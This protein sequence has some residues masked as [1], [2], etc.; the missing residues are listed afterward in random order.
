MSLAYMG[1]PRPTTKPPS[2]PKHAN[3]GCVD[4]VRHPYTTDGWLCVDAATTAAD[5]VAFADHLAAQVASKDAE[6]AA[7]PAPDGLHYEPRQYVDGAEITD[8]NAIAD[9]ARKG[10]LQTRYVATGPAT[11]SRPT[12][13]PLCPSTFSYAH[14]FGADG[15]CDH[16]HKRDVAP[17]PCPARG[18]RPVTLKPPMK[19]PAAVKR[20][21]PKRTQPAP[22]V[23]PPDGAQLPATP[24]ARP[25]GRSRLAC[26]RGCGR[27]FRTKNG[28]AWHVE[29]WATCTAKVAAAA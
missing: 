20:P 12:S 26:P 10:T 22:S 27:T 16:C 21:A 18:P 1:R 17:Y 3:V 14:E 28:Q 29:N 8:L 15:R 24:A 5:A 6:W 7:R 11:F 25:A 23:A 13:G 4:H 2:G 19:P 9:A